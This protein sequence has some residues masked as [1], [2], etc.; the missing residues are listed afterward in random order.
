MPILSVGKMIVSIQNIK[1]RPLRRNVYPILSMYFFTI[2][3]GSPCATM[4]FYY[5]RS[6]SHLKTTLSKY[7]FNSHIVGLV[8]DAFVCACG[9]FFSLVWIVLEVQYAL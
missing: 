3:V 2:V 9:H 4:Y 1:P 7:L 8:F 5:F 6:L